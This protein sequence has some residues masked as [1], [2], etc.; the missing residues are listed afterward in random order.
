MRKNKFFT[1]K[2]GRV[3]GWGKSVTEAKANL[4]SQIKGWCDAPD[5]HIET[6][7]GHVL[8]VFYVPNGDCAYRILS[9]DNIE[10]H[11]KIHHPSCICNSTMERTIG[12]ARA[13]LAQ[14]TWLPD[15]D[16]GAHVTRAGLTPPRADDLR[17]WMKWQRS[18]A[19]LIGEGKTP[20][21]AHSLASGF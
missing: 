9:P 2:E 7:F 4:K 12:E 8:I 3:E 11:G 5:P 10:T 15:L 6:R 16:D 18:Y 20:A 17:R 14:M 1:V 21:E 19:R 13:H